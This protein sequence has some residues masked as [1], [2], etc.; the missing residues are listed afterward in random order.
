MEEKETLQKE[1]E[2][3]IIEKEEQ[4]NKPTYKK[5]RFLVPIL[6][7]AFLIGSAIH[8]YNYAT[9]HISTDDAFVEG[10]TIQIAPKVS[11]IISKIYIDDNQYVKEGDILAEIDSN[12]YQTQSDQAQAKLEN[13]VE[14]QK[15]ASVN[16]DLT[17]ITSDAAAGQSK[18]LIGQANHDVSAAQAQYKLAQADLD[19]YTKLYAKGV[20][21]KQDHD[22][23]ITTY[24][25]ADEKLKVALK[26]LDQAIE[27]N[28]GASTVTQQVAISD[29]QLKMANA[30]IKQLAAA[31]KQ[32][33]LNLGYT[34]IYAP[35]DG[36]VT[37]KAV[38][39]GAFVQIGQPL[40]AIVPEERWII[41]NFK[42]TQ[43]TNM[44]IGQKVKIKVDT[45]P[46]KV[47][48][49]KIDSI[50]SATG[51]KA[52]LFP[53]ENAVGSFVKV[54]QRVPVKIVFTEKPDPNY[55]IVP[56]MSVIPEV[57]IK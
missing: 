11:G 15:G 30:E 41:A 10:R 42:E 46:N 5:K 39:K 14:K 2:V 55:I 34:K 57:N 22:K 43:L 38:E 32:A 13:A 26:A 45:Y 49:G 6:I 40:L 17:S 51:S 25:V 53:P 36:R 8:Y 33:Q 23:A 50:Q 9:S 48:W 16:V 28:K 29:S 1:T 35:K 20:V 52:S 27:K 31:A 56:G 24:K 21:S 7:G 44:K 19:R 54:V 4:G 12:D 18:A 37:S 47:F 3:K